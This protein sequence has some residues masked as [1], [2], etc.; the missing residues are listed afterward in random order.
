MKTGTKVLIAVVAIVA[1]L[2]ISVVGGYNGLVN[3]SEAAETSVSEIDNQ[4]QRR[5]DL[6]P[7]L[8][9][10]VQQYAAHETEIFE[11]VSDARARLAG[12]GNTAETAEASE[13]LSGALNRLIA[14]S[15][16]Y[17]DLKANQNFIQLQD[18][19][20]GTENRIANARRDYNNA[21]RDLNTS[22]RRFPTNILANMFGFDRMDYFETSEENREN[23]DVGDLFGA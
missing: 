6:V 10:T 23:P 16:A 15:E 20:A 21:A 19:L 14:I 18:E 1:V 2:L 9:A 4:L 8:V 3:K 17:P 5:S 7:N 12:A 22:I 13:E 11:S